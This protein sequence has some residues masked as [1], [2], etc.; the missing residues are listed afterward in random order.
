MHSVFG[1]G[2]VFQSS[3]ELPDNPDMKEQEKAKESSSGKG[4]ER[5]RQVYRD[6]QTCSQQNFK[7]SK[8]RIL[9]IDDESFNC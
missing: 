3:F 5:C 4:L 8:K 6:M 9:I 1:E 7:F 2:S